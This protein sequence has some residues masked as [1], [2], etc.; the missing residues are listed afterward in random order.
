MYDVLWECLICI[1]LQF[2]GFRRNSH[3]SD[4]PTKWVQIL[5]RLSKSFTSV[6][7]VQILVSIGFISVSL[8]STI[9]SLIKLLYV[10]CLSCIQWFLETKWRR[11]TAHGRKWP[12]ITMGA[13]IH[14]LIFGRPFV[15][16]FA[17]GLIAFAI[18]PLSVLSV[19]LSVTLVYCGHLWMMDQDATWYRYLIL[20][21]WWC[22]AQ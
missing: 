11:C 12:C 14:Q 8:Q 17:N 19:C 20:D 3:F 2:S 7:R 1:I 16:R 4:H 21:T 9:D 22:R 5:W 6:I 10:Y 15:E 13:P 18:G